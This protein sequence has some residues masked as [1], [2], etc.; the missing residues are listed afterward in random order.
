MKKFIAIIIVLVYL[1]IFACVF[2][3]TGQEIKLTS[4]KPFTYASVEA[5]KKGAVLTT[6]WV[7]V[8]GVKAPIY[9]GA[10]GGKFYITSNKKGETV[11]KYLPKN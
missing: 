9:K 2:S 11:R 4:G 5:A 10:R 3:T 1:I 6:E 7:M 8:K